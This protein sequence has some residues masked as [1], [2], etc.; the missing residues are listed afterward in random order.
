MKLKLSLPA[1][2]FVLLFLV[3]PFAY[4]KAN[5]QGHIIIRDT[6]IENTLRRW[7]EPVIKAAGLEPSAINFILIQNNDLN[8]FVAGGPNIFIYTGL[9]TSSDNAGEIIGVIAHELG[10]IRG[11]HLVRTRRA[12]ENA[13]YET[14]LGTLLGIGAAIATGNGGVGAAVAAGTQSSAQ[15]RFFGFSRIQESSADQA[16]LTYMEKAAINPAGLTS[17]MQKLESQELL[18]SS[19]QS[20]YIRTHPL[21]RD[22]IEALRTGQERSRWSQQNIPDQWREDHERML[23]KLKGFIAPERVAWDYERADQSIAAQYA[24]A[25][26]D[27]RQ[28]REER[29]LNQINAL[30]EKEPDNPY[31]LELKGQVLVDFGKVKE[32]LSPYK[33]AVELDPKASL[34]RTSYA[35]AL[36]ESAGD[37]Q[38]KQLEDAIIHLNRATSDEP[39]STLNHRLL[40]TAY[41]RLGD[42]AM[43]RL[44]LAEEAL[45][46]G[47]T[48]YAEQ[49]AKIA[50]SKLQKG[51]RAWI[52]AQDILTFAEQDK[53]DK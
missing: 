10:H 50:L 30:L 9:L 38:N 29:A 7:S 26:A 36:I 19:Q 42:D 21:T 45:L 20:E 18:P 4:A 49:Q 22:R 6:E 17:F 27:Y 43:A 51:S 23:A 15:G 28:G 33:K 13:G 47:K 12:I 3:I 46:Q 8:A 34:I 53:K 16:A 5:K 32:S 41:G 1:F 48:D 44:H 37:G 24:R 2:I 52:R 11:G 31:F 14:M 25:I 35:H 40:A 39:R